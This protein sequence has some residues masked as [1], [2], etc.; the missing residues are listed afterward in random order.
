MGGC[1]NCQYERWQA[2][3]CEARTEAVTQ[4]MEGKGKMNERG[5]PV[6]PGGLLEVREEEDSEVSMLAPESIC[7]Q[8]L[9][10][11]QQEQVGD[12]E[13]MRQTYCGEGFREHLFQLIRL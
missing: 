10:R 9:G 8:T 3:L 11:T 4:V 1:L 7:M 13:L 2:K 6:G 12:E 5:L